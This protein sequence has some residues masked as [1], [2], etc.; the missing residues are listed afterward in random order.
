MFGVEAAVA[1]ANLLWAARLT[2]QALRVYP[3]EPQDRA[4]HRQVAR[5]AAIASVEVFFTLVVWKRSEFFFLDRYSHGVSDQIALYSI[6]FSAVFALQALP[7]GLTSVLL[8][9]V[10]NLVGAGEDRRLRIGVMRAM[11][12]T[13]T[14]SLPLAA[15][16]LALGP[17]A[18][19]LVYG[20]AFKG[21][22]PLVVVM[23]VGF[24][25]I[26]VSKVSTAL[27]Q[28]LGR[29]RLLLI[30]VMVATVIDVGLAV[31]LVPR[32]QALGAAI[33]NT[34]AQVV[35]A[36]MTMVFARRFLGETRWEGRALS[37]LA[38]T[39]G[40]AVAVAYGAVSVL[41]A[42]VGLVTGCVAFAAVFALLSRPLCV[43]SAEDADWLDAAAG[44]RMHGLVGRV[45]RAFVSPGERDRR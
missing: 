4:L 43:I 18:L 8:P 14:M 5:Y 34:V 1:A 6:A 9:A 17:E 30:S 2:S 19:R 32:H 40:A 3:V 28:G 44:R 12:L 11:R 26:M 35:A 33:A 37:G 16:A 20:S 23:V 10:A 21:T 29:Q 24:P 38:I 45:A 41:P 27:L 22:A 31:W 7:S 39:S 13:L 25:I 15:G 36:G 42:V